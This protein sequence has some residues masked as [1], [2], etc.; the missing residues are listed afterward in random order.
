MVVHMEK[1]EKASKRRLLHDKHQVHKRKRRQRFFPT[2]RKALGHSQWV[3]HADSENGH[4]AWERKRS[5]QIHFTAKCSSHSGEFRIQ[6]FVG[7][8]TMFALRKLKSFDSN[9]G[10]KPSPFPH[11][12]ETA[13]TN[14]TQKFQFT[15]GDEW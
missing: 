13:F 4:D 7:I 5:V 6:D 1:T 15:T 9:R 10:A 12:T 8:G 3:R 14:A 2:I 11:L